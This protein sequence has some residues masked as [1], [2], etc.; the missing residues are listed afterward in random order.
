M[1]VG[2]IGKIGSGKTTSANILVENGFER[3][4][5]AT[6][7]K[8]WGVIAKFEHKEMYG[9]QDDKL[10]INKIHGISGREFMQKVGSFIRTISSTFWIDIAKE[11]IKEMKNV[12][13]EDVRYINEAKAI[14]DMGGI[15]IK[16][17]RNKNEV[18]EVNEFSNHSSEIEQDN[19][20]PDYIINNDYDINILKK[21]IMNI[22]K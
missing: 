5:F 11:N 7:L 8:E 2:F 12:V 4:A 10:N 1:I 21:N 13:I 17:I 16:V 18:N 15:L 3:Y 14:K 20:K 22:I 19:I 6:P 9:T